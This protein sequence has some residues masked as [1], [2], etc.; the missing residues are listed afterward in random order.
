MSKLYDVIIIGSGPAGLAA[1]LY[2]GRARLST[3]IIEKDKDGGQIVQ[4]AEIENYP[5]GLEEESGPTLIDRMSRQADHF[6]AEKVLDTIVDM[7]LE[8]KEKI[9]TG[10][11]DTYRAKTVIIAAGASPVP[12]GCPGE[13][14][15][16]GKG[17][18]YCATC[19]AA[20]FED[21]EVFVVGGGDSAVEEALYLTKF[22]RKV[23]I[24][25]RRDA[26]RAAKSIQEKA[27][28][29]KKIEFMWDSV[30]KEL[31]GDGLLE[32]MVVENVKTKELTEVTADEED[33][34]FG[35]F[36]FIG[37]KPESEVFQGKVEMEKGYIV[38]DPDMK[39]SVDGVF[40]AGDIRV[41]SLRQVV[42]AAADGAIAAVQAGKYIEENE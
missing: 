31:K 17:V 11:K 29:N 39:T 27:F 22:A 26:L 23:T 2:A 12:I 25:H 3:L 36:V 15:F 19:D 8:G 34:T 28:A 10:K 14:E 9:L 42:T 18:S 4:T 16:T 24:I 35:V 13:K 38:T 41:K 30:V 37:F 21:F 5:G 20:F 1:G 33:G 6:G 40:A 32:S 7:E